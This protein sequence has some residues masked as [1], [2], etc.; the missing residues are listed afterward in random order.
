MSTGDSA[1]IARRAKSLIPSG[2]FA[3]SA[4]NYNALIGGISDAFA[5]VYSLISDA[6]TQSR[7]ATRTGFWLDVTALDFFGT[8]ITRRV[9]EADAP[10]RA[11]IKKEVFRERATRAGVIGAMQDLTGGGTLI[12][13]WHPGDCGAYDVPTSGY[14]QAG[15]LGSYDYPYQFLLQVPNPVGA[16]VPNVTG[17]DDPQGGYDV[18]GQEEYVDP[19]QFGGVVTPV[20][21]YAA[22]EATR[23]A[24]VTAWVR[25]GNVPTQQTIYGALI[26]NKPTESGLLLLVGLL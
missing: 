23:A 9:S 21:I 7:L 1:D 15:V 4:P 19:T 20:E 14:D 3:D 5:W 16:G 2:W 6:R 26:F 8:R 10:F 25:I 22:V 24:G 17:W 12:E 11:R 18:G 13:L